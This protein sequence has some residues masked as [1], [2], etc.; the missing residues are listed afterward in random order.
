VCPSM[1]PAHNIPVLTYG[2]RQRMYALVDHFD[3]VATKHNLRYWLDGGTLLGAVR[4]ADVIPW[5]DDVDICMPARDANRLLKEPAIRNDLASGGVYSLNTSVS[6][7]RV[8]HT[9]DNAATPHEPGS[10][11][12]IFI[13][14]PRQQQQQQVVKYVPRSLRVKAMWPN[15]WWEW[16]VEHE[17]EILQRVRFGPLRLPVPPAKSIQSYLVRNYGRKWCKAKISMG[18]KNRELKPCPTS[19]DISK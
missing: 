16:P 1:F 9:E 2:E 3:K 11:I 10:W 12:D 17:R 18:H 19:I 7:W 8:V 14:E 6:I 13:V 4:H 5:D 15:L